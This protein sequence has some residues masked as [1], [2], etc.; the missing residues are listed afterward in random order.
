M[1]GWSHPRR[2]PCRRGRA[3]RRLRR[4]TRRSTRRGCARGSTGCRVT[5]WRGLAVYAQAPS[6]GVA[7][8][9]IGIAPA[10]RSRPTRIESDVAGGA[11]ANHR[12]PRVVGMPSQS[13][14]SFTPKGTPAR[15]ASSAPRPEPTAPST[16]SAAASAPSAS[17][18]TKAFSPPLA[19]AMAPR[20]SS[21]SLR[22]ERVPAL[23]SLAASRT[24][25]ISTG[26]SLSDPRA[27]CH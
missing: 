26:V 18:C 8:L 6:S 11:S 7:V 25:G 12:E 3:P 19:P 21:T 16:S 2:S 13:S 9:P 5:P 14:R 10:A 17:M 1:S 20:Q 24:V 15:G 23:I 27:E 4:W 22:E